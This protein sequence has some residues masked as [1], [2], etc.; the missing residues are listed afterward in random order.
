[1][2]TGFISNVQAPWRL[3]EA[4]Q[5]LPAEVAVVLIRQLIEPFQMDTTARLQRVRSAIA[6]ANLPVLR[7]EVHSIKGSASQVGANAMSSLCLEME[8]TIGQVAESR[9]FESVSRLESQ[10]SAAV[11]AMRAY[12]R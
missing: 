1:M 12:Q 11:S 10:L 7:A 5:E 8:S 3:P 2:H 9:L 4:F 6:D